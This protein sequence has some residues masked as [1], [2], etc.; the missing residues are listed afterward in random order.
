MFFACDN[1]RDSDNSDISR[2]RWNP[3]SSDMEYSDIKAQVGDLIQYEQIKALQA[4][5]R[6]QPFIYRQ[7]V[8]LADQ[9]R[10]S[11]LGI[12]YGEIK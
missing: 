10:L 3:N 4:G 2:T 8:W 12:Y 11:R 1:A 6:C 5:I 9:S 7:T